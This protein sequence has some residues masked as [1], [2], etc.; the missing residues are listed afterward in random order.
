MTVASPGFLGRL[1]ERGQIWFW[2]KPLHIPP[3]TQRLSLAEFSSST[4]STFSCLR[5]P[6]S[7]LE[8]GLPTWGLTGLDRCKL[9]EVFLTSF[10]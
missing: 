7:L 4:F 1:H 10:F 5:P 8:R 2:F 6:R 9:R 3:T